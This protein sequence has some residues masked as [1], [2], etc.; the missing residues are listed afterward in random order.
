MILVVPTD[1]RET[2]CALCEWSLTVMP[3]WFLAG[4][5]I[6]FRDG[7]DAFDSCGISPYGFKKQW[8]PKQLQISTWGLENWNKWSSIFVG[9]Q[10]SSRELLLTWLTLYDHLKCEGTNPFLSIAIIVICESSIPGS[11]GEPIVSIFS[12]TATCGCMCMPRTAKSSY[13]Q[14]SSPNLIL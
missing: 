10:V 7:F 4:P 2:H 3:F 8:K 14:K 6:S 5:T 1:F 12:M 9:Q 11:S 13:D